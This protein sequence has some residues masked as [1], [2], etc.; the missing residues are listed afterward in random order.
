[1]S[2]LIRETL[3]YLAGLAATLGAVAG[4]FKIWRDAKSADGASAVQFNKNLLERVEK[5]EGRVG[6]LERELDA[7]RRFSSLALAFIERLAWMWTNRTGPFPPLP[8]PL[9][10]RMNLDYLTD[11]HEQEHTETE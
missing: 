3:P 9:R 5:L 6:N 2:S 10:E 1:M 4:F 11:I 7:E 8:T